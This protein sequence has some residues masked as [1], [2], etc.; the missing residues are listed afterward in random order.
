MK[1]PR[2]ST[3]ENWK[4]RLEF[5]FLL[6]G[7]SEEKSWVFFSESLSVVV[8]VRSGYIIEDRKGWIF[9]N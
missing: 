9:R 1:F 6:K 2:G 3:S 7:F 4:K 8:V 5:N